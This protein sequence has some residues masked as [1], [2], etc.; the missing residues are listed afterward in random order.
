MD[1]TDWSV[2]TYPHNIQLLGIEDDVGRIQQIKVSIVHV[3][4][5]V[6]SGNE[7][8]FDSFPAMFEEGTSETRQ[9]QLLRLPALSRLFPLSHL[10][11]RGLQGSRGLVGI[12]G[13]SS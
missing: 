4:E 6:K 9:G 12:P 1:H 5:L 2:V 10:G 3:V 13:M 11:K 8:K 7:V